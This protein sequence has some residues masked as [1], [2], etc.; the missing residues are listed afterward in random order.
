MIFWFKIVSISIVLSASS[1]FNSIIWVWSFKKLGNSECFFPH[2]IEP[3]WRITL[4]I[5]LWALPISFLPLYLT[6]LLAV[7]AKHNA[8]E[9]FA[10]SCLKSGC[11]VSNSTDESWGLYFAKAPD[12]VIETLL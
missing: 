9:G 7:L 10:K 11:K 3:C 1:S 6:S 12:K 5:F 8:P 2:R 4:F